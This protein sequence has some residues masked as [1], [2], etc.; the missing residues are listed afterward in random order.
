ML[1]I[2]VQYS[3]R[4]SDLTRSHQSCYQEPFILTANGRQAH[5]QRR[6]SCGLWNKECE[7]IA[8]TVYKT[9]SSAK[10]KALAVP[11]RSQKSLPFNSKYR[12]HESMTVTS[13]DILYQVDS[14]VIFW[15][16]SNILSSASSRSEYDV[17]LSRIDLYLR[18]RV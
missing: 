1:L 4:H 9:H 3:V 7:L 2:S 11:H 6:I 10:S 18:S 13:T 8:S 5:I 12:R 15:I 14:E 16:G 17:L